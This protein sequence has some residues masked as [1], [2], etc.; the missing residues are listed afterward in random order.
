MEPRTKTPS[1]LILSH[2]QMEG[3]P[4]LEVP[5]ESGNGSEASPGREEEVT[6]G[7]PG[8]SEAGVVSK[9]A[10]RSM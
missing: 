8:S 10:S 1:S 2:T 5:C 9:R 6:S 7:S 4:L 3:L